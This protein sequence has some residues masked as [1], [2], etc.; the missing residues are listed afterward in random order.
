ML[1][2]EER[3]KTEK[4]HWALS[5]LIKLSKENQRWPVTG[6][7]KKQLCWKLALDEVYIFSGSLSQWEGVKPI[8]YEAECSPLDCLDRLRDYRWNVQEVWNIGNLKCVWA[9]SGDKLI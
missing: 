9:I 8:Y 3:D 5:L 4:L 7:N 1:R 2:A 6:I